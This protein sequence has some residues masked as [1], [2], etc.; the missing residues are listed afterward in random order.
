M[1]EKEV[2]KQ[3]TN[4][5]SDGVDKITPTAT[6]IIRQYQM[7]QLVGAITGIFITIVSIIVSIIL[8]KKC[9]EQEECYGDISAT[10]VVASIV[11]T[12]A[13]FIGVAMTYSGI[14]NYV[15]PITS[16]ISSISN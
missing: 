14:A 12:V 11:T 6:E 1:D 7:S 4:A 10:C 8:Y 16:F 2:V 13:F 9:K 5:I 15:S 3:I